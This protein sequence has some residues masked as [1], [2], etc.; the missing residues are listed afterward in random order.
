[1]KRG[2]NPERG[3][4]RSTDGGKTWERVLFRD[5]K[6]GAE[7]LVYLAISTNVIPDVCSYPDSNKT[8]VRTAPYE[9]ANSR[10]LI[11]DASKDTVG[12]W[13]LEDGTRVAEIVAGRR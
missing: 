3:V 8:S 1:M 12:Y 4:F 2:R 7:D 13:D 9:E 11:S 10:F 5:E 6:T